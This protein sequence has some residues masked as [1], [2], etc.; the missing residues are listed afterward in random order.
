MTVTHP[1]NEPADLSG[2]KGFWRAMSAPYRGIWTIASRI[3]LWPL[4]IMPTVLFV[5][6]LAAMGSTAARVY[7]AIMAPFAALSTQGAV[8]AAGLWLTKALVVVGLA[9]VVLAISTVIVPAVSAPFMDKIAMRVDERRLEEPPLLVGAWRA[10]RVTLAGTV[11][12]GLPQIV[13]A[14]LGL[15]ISPLSWLFGGL[16][17]LLSALALA[18]DAL[19]WPLARRGLGVRARLHWMGEHKRYVAGLGLGVWVLSIV[20]GLAMVLLAGIVAGGVA[21]VNRIEAVEGPITA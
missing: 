16:A 4:A 6:T 21:L 19:D 1:A 5:A 9:V 2:S 8:G 12:F 13:M 15:A 18:Y 7:H 3:D 14:L 11:M 20:P 10:I 17:W